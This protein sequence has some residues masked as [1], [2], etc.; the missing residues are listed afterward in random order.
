VIHIKDLYAM[1]LKARTAEELVSVARKLVYVPETARL[2]KLLQHFLE[3]KLHLAIVVDEYGGTLGLVTLENILEELVGQ[4]Q[5]EFD[6]EKPLLARTNETTWEVSGTLPLHELEEVVGQPLLAEGITTVSGWMTHRLGGFPKT[7][8]G[9]PIGKFDLRV[10]QMEGM[11]VARLKLT[12]RA[13]GN[14]D[15]PEEG[16]R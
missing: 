15:A 12:R 11:R 9:V 5:D 4:I 14:S 7:G 13:E 16:R 10:E 6:Q 8:D 3:R 2:E 1:R